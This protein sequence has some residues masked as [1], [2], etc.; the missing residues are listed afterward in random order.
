MQVKDLE[1][2]LEV[3][4]LSSQ[5]S[6]LEEQIISKDHATDQL[7]VEKEGLHAR[8]LEMEKLQVE[9]SDELSAIQ[10]KLKDLENDAT[11]QSKALR[12]QINS[13]QQELDSLQT[14]KSQLELQIEREKQESS[15]SLTQLEK[16]KIELTNKI[17]DQETTLNGQ[18][19]IIKKL[20]EE[21]NQVKDRFLE[22]NL[23]LQIAERK[24]EEMANELRKKFEDGLRLLSRRIRVAEQLHVENKDCYMKT[25]ER[26]EQEHVDLKERI[27]T[28]EVAVRRI[29]DISLT[30]NE[31]LTGLDSVALKFEECGGNFLN[32]I[33]KVSCELKF[34]R[35]WV[36]RKNNGIKHVK[37]D[38]DCLLAQLD[39][40]EAKIVEF[41]EKHLEAEFSRSDSQSW[42]S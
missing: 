13:L 27:T 31:M 23:N 21:N 22:S 42:S 1:L 20:N 5:K 24:T 4:S 2:E 15:K 40:K 17:A 11:S 29:K 7:R 39:V 10:A 30:A 38:V 41:R 6:E 37:E 28:N 8:I 36:R 12:A 33:S 25:K 34:A 14:E 18:D 26:Y 16:Q 19:D 3:N 32:R 9:R 35:D